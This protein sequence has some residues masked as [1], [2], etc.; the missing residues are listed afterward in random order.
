MDKYVKVDISVYYR[1]NEADIDLGVVTNIPYV[2]GEFNNRDHI[3]VHHDEGDRVVVHSIS[4][5]DV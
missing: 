5:E 3:D 1:I 4:V 2:Q